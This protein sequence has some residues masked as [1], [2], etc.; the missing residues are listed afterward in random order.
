M[1]KI[2]KQKGK[3]HPQKT[4][5]G[6]PLKR[7]REE[8]SLHSGRD[9]RVRGSREVRGKRK[10][11]SSRKMRAMGQRFSLRPSRLRVYRPTRF[12]PLEVRDGAEEQE[13]T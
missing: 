5:V 9:D 8:R 4:R 12:I 13:Q 6:H 1:P 7:R 2:L 3:T 11:D 10:A